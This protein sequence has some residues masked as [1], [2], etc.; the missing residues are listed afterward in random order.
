MKSFVPPRSFVD[1]SPNVQH[2]LT[3]LYNAQKRA[4][5][6]DQ[7][8]WQFAEE[9]QTFLDAGILNSDLRWLVCQGYVAHA[10]ETTRIKAQHRTFSPGAP[11]AF[12]PRTCFVLT[13]AGA[14]LADEF[15]A[16]DCSENRVAARAVA[17]RQYPVWDPNLKRLSFHGAVIKEFRVPSPNQELILT[18]FQELNWVP[19]IDDPL[20]PKSNIEP[21]RRLHDT[22]IRLNRHHRAKRLRFRGNGRGTGICWEV[23]LSQHEGVT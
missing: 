8:P 11:L 3:L 21:C 5:S 15:L 1:D 18:V 4:E 16:L 22:I 20:P 6:L 19:F 14:A 10:A 12:P 7:D 9:I 13:E 2:V 17:E 23:V